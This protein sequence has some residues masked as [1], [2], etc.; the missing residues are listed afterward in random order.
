[1][2]GDERDKII[3]SVGYAKDKDGNKVRV[4]FGSLNK[5][6]GE[7]RLNVAVTRAREETII[8]SSI[9]PGEIPLDTVKSIGPKRLKDF[10]QYAKQVNEGQKEQ[11]KQLLTGL[12]P[13]GSNQ[14]SS[15]RP[16]DDE[17]EQMVAQKIKSKGYE[18]VPYY[19]S[20]EYHIDLA[21]VNPRDPKRFILGI[22]CDG[23]SLLVMKSIR[24][25][26]VMIPNFLKKRGWELY[27]TWS[28]TWWQNP[29]AELG[30]IISK[31]DDLSATKT[32]M[33]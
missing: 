6:G 19:G 1:M 4:Q 8:V 7:N 14:N 3:F 26:D 24:D 28:R 23:K 9:E 30:R 22:E 5:E 16:H 12:L 2:Q 18:V 10:L 13:S 32:I 17:F 21:V 27:R 15:I 11:I 31:I 20:S 33:E 29:E 25:R